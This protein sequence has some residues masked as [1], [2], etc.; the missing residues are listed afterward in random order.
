[1][2]G[3]AEGG[4]AVEQIVA[5]ELAAAVAHQDVEVIDGTRTVMIEPGGEDASR[6]GAFGTLSLGSSLPV[7]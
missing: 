7:A 3:A 1:M 6:V 2:T 5:E 4:A